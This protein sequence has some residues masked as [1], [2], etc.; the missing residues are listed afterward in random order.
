MASNRAV[1]SR[2]RTET[3]VRAGPQGAVRGGHQHVAD[4]PRPRS[5]RRRGHHRRDRRRRPL[6]V[7]LR[8][9]GDDRRVPRT[10]RR[11]RAERR[12]LQRGLAAGDELVGA[13][14]RH[15]RSGGRRQE[16][17]GAGAR[18]PSRAWSTST[19]GRCT[20]PSRSRRC[21][22]GIDP[23]DVDRV[24]ELA[25]DVD[26]RGRRH[27]VFVDGFDA[28]T[29]IR[30]PEVTTA[31]SAVAAN[32]RVRT[33]LVQRQRQMGARARR[34]GARGSR[35]RLGRVPRRRAEV[36]PHRVAPGACR[37]ALGRDRW[38]RRRD[39]GG[40]R[41]ARP[42]RHVPVAWPTCRGRWLGRGRYHGAQHRPGARADRTSCWSGT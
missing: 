13:G 2:N 27:G 6:G 9:G 1:K 20:A 37:A 7:H 31:V 41:A 25:E 12:R 28:T 36:A 35:H 17:R 16:H 33:E 15:R 38:R 3:G 39:R 10:C 42:A 22:A 29:D 5:T 24:A 21:A 26:A 14:H 30:S 32:S 40:D 18:R 34:R 11:R 19:R 23:A 8:R 4:V